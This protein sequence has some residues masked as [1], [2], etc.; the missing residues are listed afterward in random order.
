[1]KTYENI[2]INGSWVKPQDS[3]EYI[4][5][6]NPANEEIIAKVVLGSKK[7]VDIAAKAA[8]EAFKKFYNTSVDERINLLESILE[9]YKKRYD[10]ICLAIS[11]EMGAPMEFTKKAQAATGIGH[12]KQ[13][14]QTLKTYNFEE[15]MGSSIIRRE[16]IGVVGM[17]TP[18]N[19]PINQIT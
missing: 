9:N 19:W 15:Q 7:D 10:D 16:A 1:M 4:D 6:I 2:F 8:K 3:N 5:V 11:S 18:W 17:I 14:I 12:F 13:A